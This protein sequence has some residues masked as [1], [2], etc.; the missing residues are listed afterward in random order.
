MKVLRLKS[1]RPHQAAAEAI[2]H[3]ALLAGAQKMKE[4]MQKGLKVFKKD[5]V[6]LIQQHVMSLIE[7]QRTQTQD[8]L[9][10]RGVAF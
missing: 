5:A 9:L 3:R 4:K 6:P 7:P 8:T 10:K 1:S 2:G